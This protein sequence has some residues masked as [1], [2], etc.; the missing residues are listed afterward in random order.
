MSTNSI[1]FGDHQTAL[2]SAD[3]WR[4]LRALLLALGTVASIALLGPTY[5]LV[6]ASLTWVPYVFVHPREGLWVT[7]ALVM[8]ASIVSPPEGFQWGVGYSPELVFWAIAICLV[9][10]TMLVR[11]F[12][13]GEKSISKGSRFVSGNPPVAFYAL[14][15]VSLLAAI[16]GVT[17]G[18][19]L[20]NVAKQLFGCAL[21]CGYF[22][23][24][25]K[26][27]PTQ[28]DIEYVLS[29]VFLAGT[30]CAVT[31][32]G[33][34]LYHVPEL[35]F[36]KDLTILSTY[37]GGL[38]VLLMPQILTKGR[39]TLRVQHL[40]LAVILFGVPLL[41]QFK[42]AIAACVICGFL[43]VG[44][45][46]KSNWRRYTYVAMAFTL[47]TLALSTSLLNPIGAWFS[48]YPALQDLFP[49]DVQT[50]YSVFL[51][52]EEFRQVLESLG[53]VPILG[54]GLGSTFSWYDPYA[55]VTWE[56]E[57][58]DVGWLYLLV[59]MGIVGTVVFVW[60]VCRLGHSALRRPLNGNHLGLFLLMVFHLLQMV[61]DTLFVYFM[62]AAWAG[63]ACG[64]LHTL[65]RGIG[66]EGTTEV[67]AS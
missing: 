22:L 16:V 20:P 48:K 60:F 5:G 27:A 65:N 19:I 45:R 2:K 4:A 67:T 29:R 38:T 66:A 24:A 52:L 14:A 28:N 42:R 56:Q 17:H 34:Y 51:R 62:T 1:G 12:W 43:V 3:Y 26:F 15:I 55:G 58:L 44:M 54:T 57:T 7:P 10:A 39:S 6:A 46:A 50:H 23:L 18:Y 13:S 31:Y 63:M 21:L 37:A 40:G 8:V 47:F 33:I 11:Y 61:A 25:L 64:F 53:T 36:R 35:G 59:K 30:L 41:A 32:L 49:Q 9:F